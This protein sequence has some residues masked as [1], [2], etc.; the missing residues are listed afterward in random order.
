MARWLAVTLATAVLFAFA[1]LAPAAAIARGGHGGGG[2]GGGGHGGG[3]HAGGHFGGRSHGGPEV[4]LA[5]PVFPGFSH[6]PG[7][8]QV[9]RRV[10]V[11][12]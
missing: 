4:G 10:P 5:A 11:C 12:S 3:G 2:N 9:N 8:A 7:C 6:R 1:A